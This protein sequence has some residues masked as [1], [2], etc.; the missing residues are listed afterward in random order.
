MC[1]GHPSP[2]VTIPGALSTLADSHV[3]FLRGFWHDEGFEGCKRELPMGTVGSLPLG[4]ASVCR[5]KWVKVDVGQTRRRPVLPHSWILSS[6][7]L[8]RRQEGPSSSM[9]TLRGSCLASRPRGSKGFPMPCWTRPDPLPPASW[10]LKEW[11][12]PPGE[13]GKVFLSEARSVFWSLVWKADGSHWSLDGV[14][15]VLG[16]LE[17]ASLGNESW[18]CLKPSK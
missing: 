12:P 18:W 17:G 4:K 5:R 9:A 8:S 14:W 3:S 16:S 1:G 11:F 6:A 10:E 15:W 13:L 7:S 2:E